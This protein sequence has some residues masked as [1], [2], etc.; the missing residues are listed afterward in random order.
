MSS[1][2]IATYS[3]ARC[4]PSEGEAKVL[5]RSYAIAASLTLARGTVVGELAATPGTVVGYS[6]AD[7]A[8]PAGAPTLGTPA[9][10]DGTIPAGVIAV[11]Y[12]YVNAAGGETTAS[13][14]AT[15]TVGATNHVPVSAVT[16]LP[17][18]ATKVN[19][20]MALPGTDV[21]QFVVQNT[22]GA[23]NLTAPPAAG[24]KIAPTANTATARTD[25]GQVPIGILEYDCVTDASGN[26]TMGGD[27]SRT[28]RSAPVYV[29]GGAQ[30]NTA[31]ITG[32]D[33]GG[34]ALLGGFLTEGNLTLGKFRW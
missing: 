4:A 13:P 15:A 3:Q 12:T 16:P 30:W 2:A 25:G 10:T 14:T 18:G 34:L 21:L 33:A 31:D 32:L 24:A 17:T 6:A 1:T 8:A 5:R 28:Y 23:F 11:A 19:W 20:Y 26:I 9:G 7:I 22:G 27:F 29:G